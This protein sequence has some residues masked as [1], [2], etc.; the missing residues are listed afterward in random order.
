MLLLAPL[1]SLYLTDARCELVQTTINNAVHAQ[2]TSYDALDKKY[3]CLESVCASHHIPMTYWLSVFLVFWRS[4]RF[5][6]NPVSDNASIHYR[7][8]P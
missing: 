2:K 3:R 6:S 7:A 8:A 5:L 1:M 4:L